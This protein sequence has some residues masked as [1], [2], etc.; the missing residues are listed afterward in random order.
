MGIADQVLSIA[1]DRMAQRQRDRLRPTDLLISPDL[2]G[3]GATDFDRGA[4]II[5]VGVAA[6]NARV[7]RLSRWSV[8]DA[9]WRAFVAKQRGEATA[10]PVIDRIEFTND[11]TLEDDVV[12]AR[13]GGHEN[14]PLDV[15]A[16]EE[17]LGA[18]HGVG[19][20]QHVDY[21]IERDR[22]ETV[23]R[24]EAR[25]K[26]WGPQYLQIGLNLEENF[27]NTS[28]YNL[29]VNY[30][31]NPLNA[32][33]GEWRNEIQIGDTLRL[34]SELW[35]PL[36]REGAWFIA[37]SIELG[38]E[39]FPIYEGSERVAEFSL[40]R[41]ELGFDIGRQISNWGEVR[42]GLV[43][44]DGRAGPLV[45]ARSFQGSDF[46]GGGLFLRLAA[47]TLDDAN[48]PRSG[49]FGGAVIAALREDLGSPGDSEL[50]TVDLIGVRSWGAQT[51]VVALNGVTQFGDR[52]E[53]ADGLSRLGG[54][55]NLSGL[56]RGQLSGAHS[57]IARAV[58][59]RRMADLGILNFRYPVYLGASIEMGNVW[60]ER[61]DISV[62]S[63][64]LGGSVFLGWA[65]PLGPLYFG[66]GVAEGGQ[67][68]LYLFLGRT[69]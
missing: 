25:E 53:R 69:F 14:V 32:L 16:L 40:R 19:V 63:A 26:A 46:D 45:G 67:D 21:Q 15:D 62:G 13:L 66:Y 4:D 20:F 39:K 48:F 6:A 44:Q 65:T 58:T 36:D 41:L 33:G 7:D 34:F 42:A 59:Y 18:V 54:F 31:I 51:F 11:S 35:Q 8:D 38:R 5:E 49:V 50:L 37:P 68:S 28:V 2:A 1:T 47:D 57:L 30:T 52:I 55:L 22:G 56:D 3:F 61:G 17:D 27:D 9:R 24:I 29:A 64:R 23:L 12:R 10:A 43:W 60:D